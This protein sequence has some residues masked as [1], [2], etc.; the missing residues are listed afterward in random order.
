MHTISLAAVTAAL[1]LCQAVV[2]APTTT[3]AI[4]TNLNELAKAKGK[5]WFGTAADI[6]KTN[7]NDEQT[8]QAYLSILTDP[9][10]FG[11]LTPA[12]IMK[13]CHRD[14]SLLC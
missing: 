7:E 6:P 13:V 2:G 10:I 5:L 1:S 8:D 9:K 3:P 14:K 12:N 4:A 11:E